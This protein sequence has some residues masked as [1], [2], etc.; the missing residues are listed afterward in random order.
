MLFVFSARSNEEE[1]DI[2]FLISPELCSAVSSERIL[3]ILVYCFRLL[4]TNFLGG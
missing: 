3:L 2:S 1:E 4:A